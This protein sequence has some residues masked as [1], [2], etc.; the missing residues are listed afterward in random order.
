MRV[1]VKHGGSDVDVDDLD[2]GAATVSALKE[3]LEAV[4][5][6]FARQQKLI[7]K[8][9]VLEDR[10]TL[11]S[12]KV[13]DGAK[14]MMLVSAQAGQAPKPIAS[15]SAAASRPSPAAR[16]LPYGR[17]ALPGGSSSS[18]N[19][20]GGKGAAAAAGGG[21]GVLSLP[22]RR[23]AWSKTGVVALRDLGLG[24]VPPGCLDGLGEAVRSAD[25]SQNRLAAVPPSLGALPC[26]ASLRLSDNALE[27]GGLPWPALAGLR[28][29]TMLAL[30]GNRLTRL[31]DALSG[32]SGLVRLAA[33]RNAIAEVEGGALAGLSALREL[34]LSANALEELPGSI[35]A[36][37]SLE[38]IGA[39]DNRL[40]AIPGGVTALGKLQSLRLD[41][42]RIKAL[43][44]GM[45]DACSSLAALLLRG[46][47]ITVE[48]LRSAPGFA[49]YERRR[50]ARTDKQ[51]GGRVMGDMARAFCEGADVE[52]WQHY[53]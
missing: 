22:E 38:D 48:A 49:A 10:A 7:F 8:G 2:A 39:A 15:S 11:A 42:N 23:A 34:D 35:G 26:L 50:R 33:G 25:L 46:N 43:P 40:V 3:R 9:K 37:S 24:E 44:P 6:V 53:R 32:C 5:G 31:P 20:S 14:L 41:N 18:N 30:D 28:G 17:A 13:A 45:F 52:Q 4:T 36:C 47:P 51:L 16:Q 21:S 12:S 19:S 29:L 1:Q 27:D